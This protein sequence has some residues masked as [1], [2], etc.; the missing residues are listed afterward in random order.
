MRNI[1][2]S[3]N[4]IVIALLSAAILLIG[5]PAAA[6][7]LSGDD[8]EDAIEIRELPFTATEDLLQFS[9]DSNDP[10]CWY[11]GPT[12]WYAYTASDNTW[13]R[14]SVSGWD[15]GGS[16]SVW[17]GDHGSLD[18]VA[19]G[20]NVR[21]PT[22]TG[23]TYY[24]MVTLSDWYEDGRLT[25]HVERT[26]PPPPPLEAHITVDGGSFVGKTGQVT[27]SGTITCSR[28]AEW[29]L[30]GN[31]RQRWGRQFINGH[32]YASGGCGVDARDWTATVHGADGVFTG[33]D[34]SV[35]LYGDAWD[36]AEWDSTWFSGTGSVKLKGGARS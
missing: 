16:V 28:R 12:A 15:A 22:A 30:E 29:W 1:S 27:L 24:V 6:E 4:G 18:E 21:F 19:C 31:I 11:G 20:G 7:S 26:S 3:S 32:L 36:P 25:L 23:E 34:V 13:I 8:L 35:W 2:N 17:T 9:R 14:A 33:G 5:M 10:Y